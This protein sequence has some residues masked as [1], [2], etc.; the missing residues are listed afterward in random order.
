MICD[1]DPSRGRGGEGEEKI[2]ERSREENNAI[3]ECSVE[4]AGEGWDG[5]GKAR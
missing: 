4:A 1:L 2:R 3:E 5:G